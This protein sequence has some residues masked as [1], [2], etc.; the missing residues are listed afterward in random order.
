MA[1]GFVRFVNILNRL[2]VEGSQSDDCSSFEANI[3]R[4]KDV[5]HN[6]SR[7]VVYFCRRGSV[8]A[9]TEDPRQNSQGVSY[10]SQFFCHLIY[11]LFS[12]KGK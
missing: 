8:H 4:E 11:S 9:Q 3:E 5:E 1:L 2:A 10:T 6:M 7:I 12:R